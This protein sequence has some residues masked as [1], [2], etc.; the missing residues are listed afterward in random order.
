M[1]G[2]LHSVPFRLPVEPVVQSG[3]DFFEP[4]QAVIRIPPYNSRQVTELS[5]LDHD[6]LSLQDSSQFV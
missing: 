2:I 3:G 6:F 1:Q 4:V 5:N